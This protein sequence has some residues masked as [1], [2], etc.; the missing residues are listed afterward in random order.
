[1]ET[2]IILILLPIAIVGIVISI[3]FYNRN[4]RLDKE[5]S[6][7]MELSVKTDLQAHKKVLE[8]VCELE[9][10]KQEILDLKCQV[11]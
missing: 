11:S 10:A 3:M 1:M 9:K 5:N 4:L 2:I 6:D 8:M 7:L